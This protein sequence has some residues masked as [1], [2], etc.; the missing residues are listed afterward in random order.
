MDA[1]EA[2]PL[3]LA[4]RSAPRLAASLPHCRTANSTLLR[5]LQIVHSDPT[6]RSPQ[7]RMHAGHCD[8]MR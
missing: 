8:H 2:S 4:D 3:A 6:V 7:A 5:F 1:E